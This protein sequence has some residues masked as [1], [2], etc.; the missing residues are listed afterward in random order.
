MTAVAMLAGLQV[1][2]GIVADLQWT[3]RLELKIAPEPNL[4]RYLADRE[5][6]VAPCRP[7]G[8]PGAHHNGSSVADRR[9]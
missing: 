2:V 8:H 3:G 4:D 6:V 7:F 5:A 1:A 9:H